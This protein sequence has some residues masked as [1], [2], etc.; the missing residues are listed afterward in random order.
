MAILKGLYPDNIETPLE[1]IQY[2][3][4]VYGIDEESNNLLRETIKHLCV[5]SVKEDYEGW[6]EEHYNENFLNKNIKP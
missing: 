2:L 6:F 5:E 1:M 3:E 4:D